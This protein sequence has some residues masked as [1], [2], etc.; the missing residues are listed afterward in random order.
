[1]SK[2]VRLAREA[3]AELHEAARRYGDRRAAHHEVASERDV[4][5]LQAR[6]CLARRVRPAPARRRWPARDHRR[7]CRRQ[8]PRTSPRARGTTR[9][10]SRSCSTA[11]CASRCASPR[12]GR[13]ARGCSNDAPLLARSRR[14]LMSEGSATFAK[15]CCRRRACP[16]GS[17]PGP[18]SRSGGGHRV[19]EGNDD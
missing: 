13:F 11:L 7:V 16:S 4:H 9:S 14:R 5:R 8:R 17:P 1:M 3:R 6:H 15:L 18:M 19:M 10:V 12:S 2:P